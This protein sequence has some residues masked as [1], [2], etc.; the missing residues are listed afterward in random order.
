[1]ESSV[2]VVTGGGRGIGRAICQRFAAK[3]AQ[4]V[5]ASRTV[6]ELAETKR[7]IEEAG[8]RCHIQEADLRMGEEIDWLIEGT[9]SRFGRID[10]LINC[11]GVAWLGKIEDLNP[12][13]FDTLLSVNV[14]AVY[15]TSRAVWPIMSGQGGGVIV[16]MSSLASVDPFPGFAAYG[17]AKAWVNLWTKALADEGRE[18]GIRVYAVAP[19]AVETQMLRSSCPQFPADQTMQPAA[20]AD[21]VFALS[22]PDCGE[23]TGRTV[24][25]RKEDS[26]GSSMER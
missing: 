5:A 14:Q 16:N 6:D 13:L 15:R 20:V 3:G 1:M 26:P 24:F 4:V 2:V 17:A 19:G 22:Q 8:G 9:R 11:A 25:V 18:C 7:I 23:E 12:S 10:A 21:V